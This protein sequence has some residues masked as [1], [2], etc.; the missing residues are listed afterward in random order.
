MKGWSGL[1]AG[2]MGQNER[3]PAVAWATRGRGGGHFTSEAE[4]GKSLR[5]EKKGGSATLWQRVTEKKTLQ[6][7]KG[8]S[9]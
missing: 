3:R 4:R 1:F 9:D 7:G 6:L 5:D 8:S 2:A